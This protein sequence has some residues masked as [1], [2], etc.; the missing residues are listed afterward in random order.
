MGTFWFILAFMVVLTF[1]AY[2]NIKLKNDYVIYNSVVAI[3][4]ET[5]VFV[6]FI[7]V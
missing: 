4:A 5:L 2:C 1:Y 3:S 7:I 6:G